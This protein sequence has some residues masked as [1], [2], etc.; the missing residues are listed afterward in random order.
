MQSFLLLP[1]RYPCYSYLEHLLIESK[2]I[3][4]IIIKMS[5]QKHSQI[6]S[7]SPFPLGPSKD[8]D[9]I[10]FALFCPHGKQVTLVM[11]SDGKGNSND[12]SEIA[13]DPEI[14]RSGNI[15]H[16]KLHISDQVICYGYRVEGESN[17]DQGLFFFPSHILIDPYARTIVHRKWGE[18]GHYGT[19]PVCL[20]G[21]HQPF[22]WQGDTPPG[23][24]LA[25]T[26]IYELHV[27]G[28]TR[29]QSSKVS[30]PGLYQGVVDKIPYLKELGITAVELLPVTEWDERDNRF[31]NPTTGELLFNF[32]GYNPISF[33]SPKSGYGSGTVNAAHD[34]KAMVRSLH[35]ENIEVIVDMVFNHS[36]ESDYEGKTTSFRG[37]DNPTY[38]LVN[39]DNGSYLNFS[40]C[41]NT[42]NCNHPV[43]R[44]LILQ[45]LRYW[46]TEMHIDGFR[47]DLAA[48]F[49]RD[50]NGQVM[51]ESPLIG[52]IA[53]DPVL[54]DV[55]IIAEAW[56]ASGL[57]QVGSFS[58]NPRW[59]EWNGR[60]RDDI[61]RFMAG[62][63]DTVRTLATRI[64]GSSDLYQSHGRSPLNS[65][66][67]ITSH[68]GFSLYDL[69]SYEEKH[70]HDNGEQNRDGEAHN[71]SW[72]SGYEG[73]PCSSDI[74]RL[75]FRRIRTFTALLFFS[76]GIPMITAG[77]E[78]G[79][80]QQGNNNSWCQ[81][82]EIGWIDWSLCEENAAL[83]RFFRKCISLRKQYPL[84]RR[85]AFFNPAGSN[86]GD[87]PDISWQ[88]LQ[89]GSQDW[90]TD[91][92]TLAFTLHRTGV[93]G[94]CDSDFFVMVNGNRE[95]GVEFIVPNIHSPGGSTMWHKIIDT[96]EVSPEDMVD[97]E[98]GAVVEPGSRVATPNMGLVVLQSKY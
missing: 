42:F 97:F 62:H 80:S 52:L 15:W 56:D 33:F 94:H 78:F 95:V 29:H 63:D 76:Q 65:I 44:E 43:C 25:D 2:L 70:N 91:C 46:V 7:G 4:I 27:R 61:R 35:Q 9:G 53:D 24:T 23:T 51:D 60:F 34:F 57:Y 58:R 48:I 64:A 67:F 45:S 12:L 55:K 96:A 59:L 82:N 8:I 13:L 3:I 49:S 14:N 54:K 81:D 19:R 36:G 71:L 39:P 28:F 98:D 30:S 1:R 68:D 20:T 38:Y 40:G 69:V 66:N 90:S 87:A 88:S 74:G 26:I 31:F 89:P 17:A 73:V 84:F 50:E 22:D 75:R 5:K 41:G 10:N 21:P 11:A 18:K 6:S 86:H 77:D 93:E 72:N 85:A 79:R 37:I 32:W 83:L 16:V 47:F 92:H